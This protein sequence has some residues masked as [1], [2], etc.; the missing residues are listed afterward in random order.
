MK[1]K[2]DIKDT[3]YATIEVEA[4]FCGRGRR[5]GRGALLQRARGMGRLRRRLQGKTG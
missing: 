1:F 2:V 3:S 4:R 5:K